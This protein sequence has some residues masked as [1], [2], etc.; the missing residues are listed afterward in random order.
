MWAKIQGRHFLRGKN[1]CGNANKIAK[2]L[3]GGMGYREVM[4]GINDSGLEAAGPTPPP[5]PHMVWSP[6]PSF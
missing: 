2:G 4:G 6:C 1:T 5:T 3:G